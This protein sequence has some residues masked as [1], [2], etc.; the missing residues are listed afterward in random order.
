MCPNRL[1]SVIAHISQSILTLV[2]LRRANPH[3]PLRPFLSNLVDT[4]EDSDGG[5][6][7]CARASVIEMFTAPTVTDGARADLK[8][9]MTKKGV[10]KG[11]VDSVLGQLFSSNAQITEMPHEELPPSSSSGFMPSR[12]PTIS[13]L[14]SSAGPSRPINMAS[15]TPVELT[16]GKKAEGVEDAVAVYVSIFINVAFNLLTLIPRLLLRVI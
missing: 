13:T 11:I 4:L 14:V 9:E 3:F 12:R 16:D 8:K 1:P 2:N 7:D 10:R 6:R 5:V 15:M